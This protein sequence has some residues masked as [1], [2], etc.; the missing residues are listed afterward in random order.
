MP[1][2]APEPYVFFSDGI[3]LS[4]DDI[5]VAAGFTEDPEAA[6][7]RIYLRFD[8]EWLAHEVEHDFIVSVAHHDGVLYG[9]GRN[10]LIK[11]VGK[12]GVA[13]TADRVAGKFQTF[14]LSDAEN[15]GHLSRVKGIED[16][17]YVCGWGGQFYQLGHKKWTRLEKGLDPKRDDDLLTLDGSDADNLYVGGLNGMAAHYDGT[18][19]HYLDLPTNAHINEVRCLGPDDF[20]LCGSDGCLLRGNH[21]GWLDLSNPDIDANFWSTSVYGGKL[22]IA[23]GDNGLYVHDKGAFTDVKIAR[24]NPHTLRLD[25]TRDVLWSFGSDSLQR[26]DGKKWTEAMCPDNA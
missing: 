6:T 4:N 21:R 23:Y 22:F 14:T 15:R 12:P 20:L 26:F 5:V 11:Q 1:K 18:R 25:S 2:K 8:D 17:F 9:V 10:G 19:W 13:L 16:Q 3:A 24:K 7:S